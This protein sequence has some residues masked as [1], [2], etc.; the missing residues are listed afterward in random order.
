MPINATQA[1]G[2]CRA[3][4]NRLTRLETRDLRSHKWVIPSLRGPW[5][6]I[7]PPAPPQPPQSTV[8]ANWKNSKRDIAYKDLNLF[9]FV[10]KLLYQ[11]S[12]DQL[13]SEFT[14]VR[15]K[16]MQLFKPL[17]IED[18]VMQS[19]SFGSPAN[20]HIAHVTWFFQKILEKHGA[21]LESESSSSSSSSG[22]NL[23]YLNSYYQQFG[24]I[25]PKQERGKFPRPTVKQTL[26]YR[27][28]ID[29]KL[30]KFL[31]ERWST[32]TTTSSENSNAITNELQY[33]IM[34]GMQHE[35]QHQELMVYDFQHFFERFPDPSDNYE[36]LII[37]EPPKAASEILRISSTM[38]D[39]PGGIFELGYNGNAF[40]YDNELPE[41]KVY[42]QPF[43][44]DVAPVTNGEYM[45]FIEDGGYEDYRYWLADGWELVKE[46][47]WNA[48]LYW[49]QEEDNVWIKK[50]FR[51][52][53]RVDPDEPVVNVSYYE[54]DAYARW[55]GKRL[56][57]E[58][59]W[60]K[61]ASWNDE[62]QRKML[63]P[64]GDQRPTAKHANLHE[65]YLWGPSKVGAYPAGK[66]YYG[67]HQMIGDVWEWTSSEYVLYPGFRSKFSEY[68]DKWTINQKVLRGGCFATPI[69]QIRNTYRNYFKPQ[70][71]ILFAGFRCAGDVI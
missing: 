34:L 65:S 49:V 40:C 53:R 12:A 20:W 56:P 29:K 44:M 46:Q 59:E 42:L 32:T 19:D 52:Q 43:K 24:K 36:P 48:P 68:T 11:E 50:D 2:G 71:R 9:S 27:S 51:G 17:R 18:A 10:S 6:Q 67:C 5:V 13:L 38:V 57:T 58:A 64:W 41:H 70:E 25:L 21:T 60:E 28:F 66:S 55:A 23:E 61:A 3:R 26:D 14:Q 7:P 54:A 62:L 45:K 16:T 35:M 47:Q 69:A 30:T 1:C 15:K 31:K 37:N 22:F 63:Y 4:P 8:Q 33:D 39:I